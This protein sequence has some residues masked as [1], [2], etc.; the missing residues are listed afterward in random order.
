VQSAEH[1]GGGLRT[2]EERH[3]VGFPVKSGGIF[4]HLV[5]FV[6]HSHAHPQRKRHTAAFFRQLVYFL[7]M[8]ARQLALAL[9]AEDARR[10]A[11]QIETAQQESAMSGLALGLPQRSIPYD[12]FDAEYE[13]RDAIGRGAF[14]VVR[15]AVSRK[16]QSE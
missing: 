10:Q 6:G 5:H 7:D 16:D 12:E 3:D 14:S 13:I 9:A 15:H 2:G 1:A 8:E 11:L 4:D